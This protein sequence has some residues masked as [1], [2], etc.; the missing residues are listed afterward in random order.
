MLYLSVKDF[1]ISCMYF[2]GSTS[3]SPCSTAWSKTQCGAYLHQRV[4]PPQVTATSMVA[5]CVADLIMVHSHRSLPGPPN[6]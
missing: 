5:Q 3:W 1:L 4:V 2:D 6:V